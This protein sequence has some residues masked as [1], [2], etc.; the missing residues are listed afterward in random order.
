MG[1]AMQ[2]NVLNAESEGPETPELQ[3]DLLYL[4]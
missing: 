1:F 2:T 3:Y 4:F